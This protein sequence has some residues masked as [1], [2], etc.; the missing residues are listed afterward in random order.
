LPLRRFDVYPGVR[1]AGQGKRFDPGTTS[2]SS[3]KRKSILGRSGSFPDFGEISVNKPP[4]RR[5]SEKWELERRRLERCGLLRNSN[6]CE[7]HHDRLR[8]ATD[9]FKD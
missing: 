6:R 4:S 8:D 2:E 7:G 3:R 5:F 9:K 1:F